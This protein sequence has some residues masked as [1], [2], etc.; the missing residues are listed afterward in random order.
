VMFEALGCGLPFIGT[1]VGGVS[2]IITSEE[3]G[4]LYNDPE[5]YHILT[6]LINRGLNKKWNN[7]KITNYSKEFTWKKIS[8]RIINIYNDIS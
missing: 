7:E 3:Y 1:N 2:E 6:E 5:D 4:L 8:K